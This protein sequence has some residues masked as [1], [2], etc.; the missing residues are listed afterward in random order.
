M[1]AV[2]TL[3]TR[4]ATIVVGPPEDRAKDRYISR[5]LV[6]S[7]GK[8]VICGG[9]TSK[10]VARETRRELTVDLTTVRGT[11]PPCGKMEGIDLV[12]E[13]VLTLAE[14]VNLLKRAEYLIDLKE[15]DGASQLARILLTVDEVRFI[16]G[17]AV[18][19]VYHNTNLPI[20]Y[21]FKF[22]QINDLRKYLTEHGKKIQ[23]EFY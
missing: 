9:T 19:P 12:T 10:I 21:G 18:N 15:R 16:V 14:T 6:A 13:G 17:K 3:P 1:L 23:I 4:R 2:K 7:E 8:R 22:R 5:E 11:L 20:D